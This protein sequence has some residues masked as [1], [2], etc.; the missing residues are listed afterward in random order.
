MA[1]LKKNSSEKFKERKHFARNKDRRRSLEKKEITGAKSRLTL[2]DPM[3]CSM[4][5]FPV[6]CHLLEF[7]QTHVH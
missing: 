5:G 4:P 3:D 6:L 1:D 2:C 7:A